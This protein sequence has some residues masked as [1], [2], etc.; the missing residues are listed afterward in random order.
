MAISRVISIFS[1]K[2]GVGKTLITANLAASLQVHL[3][4]P[5]ALVELPPAGGDAATMLG[6]V[7]VQR[8]AEGVSAASLP[9]RLATLQQ[10]CAYVLVDAGSAFS[11]AA[12]AAFE[13]SNLIILVATPDLVSIAHTHRA[14][15]VLQALKFPLNMVRV[16]INRADSRGNLPSRDVTEQFPVPVIAQIPS[17][18]RVVSLSVNQGIPLVVS[19]DGGRIQE[20]FR[21]LAR[22]LLDMPELFVKEG[23]L[24]RSALARIAPQAS[25]S[26]SSAAGDHAMVPK[27]PAP[28]EP[29]LKLRRTVH[30]KLI[31]R[32]D[33]KRLDFATMNDPVEARRLKERTERVALELISEERG[34][35]TG[36]AER[37]RLVKE[38]VDEAL[39][40]GPLEDLIAD[41]Q[42]SDILVN[43]KDKIYVER[44]GKLFLTG[45]VFTSNEQLLTVIERI[46]APL[47]RRIDE[48]APMVDARLSDGSRVN[49]IIHPLSLKGPILSIRK[50]SR[51]RYTME[52]LIRFHTLTPPMA[53]FLQMCLRVRKNIIVSGGTGSGKT[54]LLNSLSSFI[55][56][57]ERIITI[58]DAAE[59]RLGQEHWVPLEARPPNIEG[60]GQVTIRHLFRNALRMRPDRIIIGECRGDE[61][62]DM[63]QAMNTGHDGSLTTLHA[64]SPQD[65]I[66]RLDSL[67]LMSNIELPIRAIREQIVSA[68]DLIV[69]TARL[70]DGSRKLTHITEI[71]GMDAQ[72]DVLFRDLFRFVQQ[73]V[74]P[75]G[76]VLG[77]FSPTGQLPTF[78]EE[79]KAQGIPIDE[80]MFKVSERVRK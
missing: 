32:L 35:I 77:Q 58:E 17:D 1:T 76:E 39:G 53:D 24:D 7:G 79:M 78:L 8:V 66:S 25:A 20:A 23:T 47:G 36:M 26:V 69:H 15:D 80:A 63:L 59:L 45:K 54:T 68:I 44:H 11:D 71:T 28:E 14:I 65:V 33:L 50:F 10:T 57:G 12:V 56:E 49:A 73:G 29:L 55:P 61:T 27:P 5:T 38:I 18:G 70:S 16:I 74:G 37:T 48:S 64:N 46:V 4:K 22:T 43:G 31:E 67:V 52:D 72:A 30:S 13:H 75:N 34:F 60:R 2:G 19:K 41:E 51:E 21:R 40:L 42:V 6:S 9:G 3:N 62:L